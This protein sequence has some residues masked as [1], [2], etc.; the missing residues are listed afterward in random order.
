GPELA[1]PLA[2]GAG[3]SARTGP[4]VDDAQAPLLVDLEAVV[5]AAQHRPAELDAELGLGRHR[6]PPLARCAGVVGGEPVHHL[7]GPVELLVG[8]PPGRHAQ[9]GPSLVERS[10]EG[11]LP[12]V[13][14]VVRDL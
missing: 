8:D 14:E 1:V 12:R 7:L 6:S 4:A 5:A 2:L 13:T 11:L 9:A 3:G 10:E